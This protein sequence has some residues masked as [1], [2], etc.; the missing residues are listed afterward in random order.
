[1]AI[2]C[3]LLF[4]YAGWQ[5]QSYV[6]SRAALL[7]FRAHQLPAVVHAAS[8]PSSA[9]T[10]DFAL[11]SVKRMEAYK[12]SLAMTIDPPVAVL[13]IPRLKLEVPVFNGTDDLTLNRGAGRVAGTALPGHAGNIAIAAHRDGFFR[14]LKDLRLG[15][16][17]ALQTDPGD[18]VYRVDNISIVQPSDTTVL[19]PGTKPSI[20]LITCYPVYFV[21]SAP[22]RYIVHASLVGSTSSTASSLKSAVQPRNSED[23]P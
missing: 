12:E 4:V 23:M 22:H 17:V 10:I 14:S 15:D 8:T 18:Y 3:A 2:G 9:S 11:W 21:G 20:T 16:Q 5:L 13:S 1:M 19:R 6:I 7:S